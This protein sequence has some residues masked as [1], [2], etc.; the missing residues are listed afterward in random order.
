VVGG[1][2]L[3]LRAIVDKLDFPGHDPAVRSRL[4]AE[5]AA[6]GPA[7]L[8]ARLQA[9]DATAAAGIQPNNGRRIV[10]ALE[11]IATTGAFRSTLP[12]PEYALDGVVQ[13]GL[14][15]PRDEIDRRT[16]A[17]VE[18]MWAAGFVDEVR[19]LLERGLREAKTASKAIGYAQV[20]AYLDGAISEREAK[21][22]T[23]IKTRQFSR[24]QLAWW[25]RDPRIR[26]VPA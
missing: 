3:Y 14:A 16:A 23:A 25:R 9:L 7:P 4:E 15:V 5:L 10:R 24:K 12:E 17:R 11:V 13:V 1:S 18:A 26:W 8:Y 6:S 20:T 19:G 21:E 22:L 2:A